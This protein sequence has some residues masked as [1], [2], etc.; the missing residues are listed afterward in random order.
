MINM[1]RERICA[2]KKTDVVEEL[3]MTGVSLQAG[4]AAAQDQR[5]PTI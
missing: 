2:L 1:W 3:Q 4:W 5:V